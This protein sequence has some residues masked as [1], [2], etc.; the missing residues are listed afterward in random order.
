MA[1]VSQ[2]TTWYAV[3][4]VDD[5]YVCPARLPAVQDVIAFPARAVH[6]MRFAS[7]LPAHGVAKQIKKTYATKMAAASEQ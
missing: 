2:A 4:A 6:L 1:S 3:L 5:S 7:R